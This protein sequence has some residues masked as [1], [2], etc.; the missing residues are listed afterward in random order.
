MATTVELADLSVAQSE[1]VTAQDIRPAEPPLE[2]RLRDR[3]GRTKPVS[4]YFAFLS[5]VLMVLI[6]S[7]DTTMLSVALPVR[8]YHLDAVSLL[9]PDH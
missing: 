2:S 3:D 5:L 7:L 8:R 9:I 6:A 4:F 1:A